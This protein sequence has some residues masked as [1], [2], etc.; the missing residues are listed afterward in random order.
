MNYT[1][2][3]VLV[4]GLALAFAVG[5]QLACDVNSYGWDMMFATGTASATSSS[6]SS[7]TGTSTSSGTST[8]TSTSTGT[9]TSTS[10]ST[11]TSTSTGL[12]VWTLFD[13]ENTAGQGEELQRWAAQQQSAC[14][15]VARCT[16]TDVPHEGSGCLDMYLS[17]YYEGESSMMYGA[18]S[19]SVSDSGSIEALTAW[20][21]LKVMID[22]PVHGALWYSNG[23][24]PV[25]GKAEIVNESWRQVHVIVDNNSCPAVGVTFSVTDWADASMTEGLVDFVEAHGQ[26][27]IPSG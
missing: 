18:A 5:L 19:A 6:T 26:A 10:I 11:S 20:L 14:T 13:W 17:F 25:H 1:R 8:S 16:D 23:N 4:T 27:V 15:E 24:S 2:S 3:I 7:D 22:Q 12:D 21:R 9:S